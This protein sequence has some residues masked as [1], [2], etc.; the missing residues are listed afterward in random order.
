MV[1]AGWGGGWM[2]FHP[3][4]PN[5]VP[6]F[7]PGCSIQDELFGSFEQLLTLADKKGSTYDR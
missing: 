5:L 6:I 2:V 4:P 1:G 7:S 3:A